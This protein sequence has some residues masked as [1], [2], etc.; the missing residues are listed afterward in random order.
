MQPEKPSRVGAGKSE[1]K[2]SIP[3]VVGQVQATAK[4]KAEH[5]YREKH[6]KEMGTGQE[7]R[8]C[9]AK[10]FKLYSVRNR[11]PRRTSGAGERISNMI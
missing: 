5:T 4:V 1:Q 6:G 10:T 9:R 11:K 7:S 2:L 3:G 8:E